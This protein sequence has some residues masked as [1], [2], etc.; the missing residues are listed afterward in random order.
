VGVVLNVQSDH[1]GCDGI[2]TLDDMADVKG[3]VAEVARRAVVLNAH[4]E[5]CVAMADRV[6]SG[7]E[8]IYFALDRRHP[9]FARH[10]EGGGRGIYAQ[11]GILMLGHGEHRIPLVETSRLPFTLNGRARHNVENAMAAFAALLALG[12]ARDRIVAALAS[13]TSSAN[14]N[15]LRLN[16]FRT[17]G[18]TLLVD[19]AH[20]AAAY[21][22]IIDT[23]R[24][25]TQQRLI[26]VVAAPG[27]RRDDD[28][29]EM[30]RVCCE[31]FDELVIYEM[32]EVRGR[33]P[34]AT[35]SRLE[36]GA[37]RAAGKSPPRV[38][39]DVR[40]AIREAF[41]GARPGDVIVLG[42]ASHLNEL[43]DALA[44]QAEIASVNV[45]ALG[46]HGASVD[47]AL[48]IEEEN[49]EIDA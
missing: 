20:N 27:D 13:F 49:L 43:K 19:Y 35:A 30:G 36:E 5:R 16:L 38:V 45:S 18:V 39:L 42:C 3:L 12:I 14:Q 4:D 2:D 28:L 8:V 23:G 9:P 47:D 7:C 21:G 33:P 17:R 48:A 1:L 11:Q 32:D 15:P 6:R 34:G 44:G 41:R 29:L 22:A 37:T 46:L 10:L 40:E 26:G 24:Q 25:L 31:G